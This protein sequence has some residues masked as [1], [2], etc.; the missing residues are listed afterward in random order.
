MAW[1][2]TQE[3]FDVIHNNHRERRLEGIFKDLG[4]LGALGSLREAW[5]PNKP[6]KSS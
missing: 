1:R 4:D 2:S 5:Q 3:A 6:V